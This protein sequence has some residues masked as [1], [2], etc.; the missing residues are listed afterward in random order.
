M[1]IGSR[2]IL[3]FG[4][5]IFITIIAGSFVM[6]KMKTL[7]DLTESMYDHPLAV[8][9][10][11]RDIKADIIAMHRS[12]KDI[13]LAENIEQIN[14]VASIVNQYEQQVYYNFE[15]VNDRFLGNIS[16][17]RYSQQVFSNWK[18]I[19]QEVI[20]LSRQNRKTEAANITRG[21]GAQH[22]EYM[23]NEIEG[24]IIIAATKAESFLNNAKRERNKALYTTGSLLLTIIIFGLFSALF[25]THSIVYPL[26][27]IVGKIKN[28]S[29][30]SLTGNINIYRKDEIGELAD[31]FRG[32]QQDISQR[33]QI[34]EQIAL[35][36]FSSDIPPRSEN[37][38][39][40]KSFFAMTSSLK[41]TT[42]KLNSSEQRFTNLMISVPIGIAVTTIN[43]RVIEANNAIIEMFGFDS[44]K[45]FISYP[46]INYYY[47]PKD[48]ER[49]INA[50]TK[51]LV[52]NF[53]L[54]VKR[55]DGSY[56]WGSVT[57]ITQKTE[58]YGT[59]FINS[60]IDI[61][62]RIESDIL[63]KES[64]E[65]FQLLF[66]SAN[67]AIFIHHLNTENKFSNFVEVND[68]ACNSLGYSRN[69][70]LKLSPY[71]IT[72]AD[73]M[74]ISKIL[75]NILTN[76]GDTFET[77]HIAKNGEKIPVEMSSFMVDLKGKSTIISIARDVTERKKAEK[78]LLKE[79]VF[80]ALLQRIAVTANES[81]TIEEA[82]QVCLNEVCTLMEWPVGHVYM[83][84]ANDPELLQP[85]KIC[86]MENYEKF[87]SFR[88]ATT[89]SIFKSGEG[90]PGKIMASKKPSWITD[91]NNDP[92]FIRFKLVKNLG[93]KAAFGFPVLL[94]TEVVAVLE[95]F[96]VTEAEPDNKLLEVMANIGQQLG[97]V[98]ER[99]RA[100]KKLKVTTLEAESANKAKSIFL[101][102][103]SHELRTPLNAI[104]GFS[105]ILQMDKENLNAQQ[106]D[107]VGYIRESGE[108]LLEMVSDI[109][110]LSKI[111]SGKMEIDKKTFDLKSM[112]L[113]FSATI[114]SLTDKKNLKLEVDID[115]NMGMI[116][117]D[118][119][120]IKEVLYN[121]LSNAIKF[122]ETGK[123]VGIKAWNKNSLSVIEI[124]DE[125]VG[126]AEEDI[127]KI[128]D[129][130]EQVGK[131]KKGDFKGTGLGLAIT[132]KLVEAH[133]G[134]IS[135]KSD[136]G[137]GSRFRISIPVAVG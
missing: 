97:R 66:K 11:V 131:A 120:R 116:N 54:Q 14:E 39:I 12:M 115:T 93:V 24:L 20:E 15:I 136:H 59:L 111:E 77:I 73:P 133:G 61:S 113:Q 101:A 118:E 64:N 107:N 4:V 28:L 70:L 84:S 6:S 89:Q 81:T 8:S 30:G 32:L 46:V 27:I 94:G 134:T 119:K 31:S 99:S 114:Q 105:Q 36:D 37:D 34:L 33:A 52:K 18:V 60:F 117:A 67:D 29:H 1:K 74:K 55:K 124:W 90:L 123:N 45:E 9:N 91:V 79:G 78:A 63:I 132:K 129:P 68:V 50:H 76:G 65:Q 100:E 53:E 96:A 126:I 13:A 21:T 7:A 127:P 71:D 104:L 58:K 135:V 128:F 137:N 83:A 110:D 2:L 106:L 56:F 98:V 122:T 5:S 72:Y 103:M 41:T 85:T 25:I 19:R 86:H 82:M 38:D 47:N 112:L 49:F 88:E 87:S 75:N 48:R 40:G 92:D 57:S 16:E 95:F 3:A 121:L 43:G 109:L 23:M 35:G 22:V 44:K 62:E 51:G 42:A 17:V 26:G 80:V 10:S 102:N 69:E 130:F 108:H 125:G